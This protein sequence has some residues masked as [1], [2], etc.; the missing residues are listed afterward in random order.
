MGDID[1][2]RDA[3]EREFPNTKQPHGEMMRA[4]RAALDAAEAHAVGVKPDV[5]LWAAC[6]A[7]VEMGHEECLHRVVDLAWSGDKLLCEECW[8]EEDGDWDNSPS[9]LH[10]ASPLVAV[11]MREKAAETA[12]HHAKYTREAVT[13]ATAAAIMA[14]LISV[15]QTK[16]A[17]AIEDE[18]RALPPTFTD[19]ELLAAAAELPEV[20]ALQ[21]AIKAARFSF[22]EFNGFK[23]NSIMIEG[24]DA[25]IAPF[26]RKGGQ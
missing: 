12:A 22:V 15:T 7:C 24:L 10:P 4:L 11:A 16:T 9:A 2:S 1:I 6:S 3:V 20:K 19:A 13:T 14:N 26:A 21:K 17:N 8:G 18:I 25:A 23:K 5:E